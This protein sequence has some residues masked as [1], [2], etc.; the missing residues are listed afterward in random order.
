MKKNGVKPDAETNALLFVKNLHQKKIEQA[1]LNLKR[2]MDSPVHQ[3]Y[4]I[5]VSH[6]E[7]FFE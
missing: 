3:P 7:S 5:N 6:L 2:V 1:N 4:L